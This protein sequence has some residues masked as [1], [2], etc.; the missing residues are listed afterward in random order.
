MPAWVSLAQFGNTVVMSI[1]R[2]FLRMQRLNR[3]DNKLAEMPDMVA[4]RE[5]DWLAFELVHAEAQDYSI[6]TRFWHITGQAEPANVVIPAEM[7]DDP[8]GGSSSDANSNDV[9][10]N[11][12]AQEQVPELH[13]SRLELDR[14]VCSKLLP[15]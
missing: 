3:N 14:I 4:G 9:A 5:L 2:G 10:R 7:G 15:I 6:G 12:D 11:S 8:A 1:L 13:A